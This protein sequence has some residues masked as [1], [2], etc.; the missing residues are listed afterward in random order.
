MQ[1]KI[2]GGELVK[3]SNNLINAKY[4]LSLFQEHFIRL[5]IIK[6]KTKDKNFKE[7]EISIKDLQNTLNKEI[8]Y[9]QAKN[10]IFNIL[11]KPMLFEKPNSKDYLICNW[12]AQVKYLSNKAIFQVKFTDDLKPYLL[13]LKERF[14]SYN[15]KNILSMKSKYSIRIY[16]L[17]KRNQDNKL[18]LNIQKLKEIF[19]IENHKSYKRY[20]NFKAKIITPAVKEINKNSDIIISEIQENRAD[21]SRKILSITFVYKYKKVVKTVIKKINV[22]YK[23]LKETYFNPETGEYKTGINEIEKIVNERYEAIDQKT[24]ANLI[25]KYIDEIKLTGLEKEHKEFIAISKIKAKL[26]KQYEK[27]IEKGT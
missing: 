3:M 26:Q 24:K 1:K 9:K 5:I 17:L 6:I 13:E 21:N 11:K 12:F 14:L 23:N 16:E 7:Y 20:D 15:I 8:N 4:D 22:K 2:N 19:I 25:N 10:E 18:T 27:E